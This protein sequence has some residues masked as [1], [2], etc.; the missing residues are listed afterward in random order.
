MSKIGSPDTL[1][2][3]LP[4]TNGH[5]TQVERGNFDY[6]WYPSWGLAL[7]FLG[8]HIVAVWSAE[9]DTVTVGNEIAEDFR[10]WATVQEQRSNAERVALTERGHAEANVQHALDNA[11]HIVYPAGLRRD[12]GTLAI[13]EQGSGANDRV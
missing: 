5:R 4:A 13:M 3:H 2:L 7:A 12:P 10:S 6:A 11:P 8:H 9:R 1:D